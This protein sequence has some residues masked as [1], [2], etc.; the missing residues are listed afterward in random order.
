MNSPINERPDIT[1][2]T[3]LNSTPD[4][5]PQEP[6]PP[7]RPTYPA[8]T[9][10]E[11][12][13]P[14]LLL[15][16]FA[17]LALCFLAPF[18]IFGTNMGEFKFLLW[19]FWGLCGAIA[20]SAA[21]LIFGLLMLVRGRAFDICYGLIFGLSLMLFLQGNYLSLG[22]GALSGD[23]VGEGI[24]TLK[25]VVNIVIWAVIVLCCTVAIPLLRRFKETVR[26][27]SIIAL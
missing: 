18:E 1:S 9:A 2:D 10:K 6:T 14:C 17:P 16:L 13:L 11:K 15:A 27:I 25:S 4:T 21:A 24:S 20:V 3:T 19:D 23:G 22:T 7:R 8:Y 12:W 5:P 26:L